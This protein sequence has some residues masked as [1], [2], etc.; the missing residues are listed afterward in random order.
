MPNIKIS[1]I[2]TRRGTNEQLKLTTLDQ[3]EIVSTTDTKRLYI[4]TGSGYGGFVVGNKIHLPIVNYTS[5][6][7]LISEVG[8]FVYANNKY[9]QLTAVDYTNI[10]SWADVSTKI[11]TDLFNY[12]P[13][14][15]ITLKPNSISSS[16]IQSSTVLS[17]IKILNGVLQADLNTNSLE[18][19]SNKISMK[20]GGIGVREINSNAFGG[21][22]SGGS[23]N[24]IS[25]NYDPT[26]LEIIG[27][28]L[29]L[30]S[31]GIGVN[32]I[33][34]ASFGNGISGGSGN[35]I[36]LN[37][38]PS[39][40]YFNSSVLTLSSLPSFWFGSGLVYNSPIISTTLTDVDN[41][42]IGK[43][44]L[45]VIGLSTIA[46]PKNNQ[47]ASIQ[48]DQFGRTISNQSAIFD[49]LTGNSSLGTFN[50]NNSLSS[51]F[52]GYPNQALSGA[53]P[54]LRLANFTAISANGAT[55]TLSSA[56]F[57]LF[58]QSSTTR[59]GAPVGRFA[60]PIFSY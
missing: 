44:G 58:D 45:G 25:L 36:R 34:S 59:S 6:S 27:G 1:K 52:N 26:S 50:N 49:V 30:K 48:T 29:S 47:L 41:F 54:G 56:G 3:G 16:Y 2:K 28:K 7:T 21:G 5:L 20:A 10:S 51:I 42:T 22:I 39:Q 32:Q 55:I 12:T 18:I 43:N 23:G 40:F 9:Y 31:G 46:S 17:G 53:I 4:G 14:N 35:T 33:N 57:L 60:I 38:N 37:V 24:T 8:D 15:T 11:D 13:N 19:S